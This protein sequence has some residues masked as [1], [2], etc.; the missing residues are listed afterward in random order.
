MKTDHFPSDVGIPIYG[1]D[2]L[3][4]DV[5][6]VGGGGGSSRSGV[7]NKIIVYELNRL[8][9]KLNLKFEI[10]LSKDEDAPMVLA[11]SEKHKAILAGINATETSIKA[12]ENK[13]L[14]LFNF[15]ESE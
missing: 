9:S 7:K 11:S 8:E 2:F 10:D 6:V 5:I 1:L 3:S 15:N 14:R 4:N 13:D 12:G